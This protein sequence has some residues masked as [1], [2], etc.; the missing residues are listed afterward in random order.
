MLTRTAVA[1]SEPP[2]RS[3]SISRLLILAMQAATCVCAVV[4]WLIAFDPTNLM[5]VLL[6]LTS[7]LVTL[8]YVGRS[9]AFEDAPVSALAVLGLCV[10]TQWASL[11]AQTF[12]GTELVEGL[13]APMTTF[14][15]LCGVQL[16]TVL[17]HAVYRRFA[18]FQAA[19]QMLTDAVSV[20]LGLLRPP[21]A[22]ALWVMSLVGA[23]SLAV[24]GAE[25]GDA[26]GKFFEALGMFAW[27][28][29]MIPILYARYGS[30]YCRLSA[31][32]PFL[33]GF[34]V[35]LVGIGMARNARTL[36]VIG[37]VQL[38]LVVL[39][40]GLRD[41]RRATPKVISMLVAG[42]LAGGLLVYGARDVATAMVVVR[43]HR[44][45]LHPLD[46]LQETVAALGDRGK[47]ELY[48]DLEVGLSRFGVY[49]EIY[50]DNPLIARF[51]ETKFHD[52]MLF[53][54][55]QLQPQER[56]SI[57]A[58]TWDRTLSLLPQPLIDRL[59]LGVDKERL[60]FSIGDHYRSLLE[61][62]QHLG[63]FVVGSIWADLL[64]IY[65]W[66]APLAVMLI[67]VGVFL[68]L[69]M[70]TRNRADTGLELSPL[71]VC[72]TWSIFLYG[73]SADSL[74]ARIAFFLRDH[75]QRLLL[76][77]AAAALLHM[78]LPWRPAA[79][80]PVVE[81]RTSRLADQQKA[82]P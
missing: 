64:A 67:G 74:F 29:A 6:V 23:A 73:I 61:D 13:R 27:L 51:S 65:D 55:Q 19:R 22:A 77:A 46:M 10:T 59:G 56:A 39:I 70:L 26:G 8:E 78:V 69:D 62:E 4:Q 32:I 47:L 5:A 45:S 16:L 2:G 44:E 72:I 33:V 53:I 41:H 21:S 79:T 68:A 54:L 50:L 80:A 43:E 20:P 34:A 37:P 35:L 49:D 52:N 11:V 40:Y 12:A 42:A 24:S 15:V 82:Q 1:P 58:V 31:H 57:A 3:I 66:W 14:P 7:S 71:V 25:V 38:L 76:Y 60:Y 81:P 17:T 9:G 75:P 18:P 28:P 30:A 48:R 36:M 63:S